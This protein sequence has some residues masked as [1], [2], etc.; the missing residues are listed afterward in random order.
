MDYRADCHANNVKNLN[1]LVKISIMIN[2]LT[3]LKSW[4]Y[5][6][7]EKKNKFDKRYKR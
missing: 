1:I 7:A 3:L 6:L 2:D 4:E 5:N